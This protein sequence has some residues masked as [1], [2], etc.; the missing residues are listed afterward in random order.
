MIKCLCGPRGNKG[1][2]TF[3]SGSIHFLTHDTDTR[4]HM[5]CQRS[6]DS[7]YCIAADQWPGPT[8]KGYRVIALLPDWCASV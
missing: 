2:L 3:S 5:H 1:V 8:G 7:G 6:C 4:V